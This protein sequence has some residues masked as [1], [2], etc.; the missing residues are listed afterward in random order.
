MSDATSS[1]DDEMEVSTN[2]QRKNKVV[3]STEMSTD[4][5]ED[6]GESD[7]FV[8]EGQGNHSNSIAHSST[9][10]GKLYFLFH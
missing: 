5:K 1:A 2:G 4:D 10:K 6:E 8:V 7:V 3:V 9:I